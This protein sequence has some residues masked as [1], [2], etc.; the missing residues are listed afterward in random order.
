MKTMEEETEVFDRSQ[1]LERMEGDE[2][3]LFEMIE[4]FLEDCPSQMEGIRTALAA[5]DPDRLGNAAHAFKGSVG[6]FGART[7]FDAAQRLEHLARERRIDESGDA[8][9]ELEAEVDRLG[10]RLR[11]TLAGAQEG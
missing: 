10:P 3:L 9:R 8:V 7:S 6:N 2:E 4:L 11:A 1:A 5:G